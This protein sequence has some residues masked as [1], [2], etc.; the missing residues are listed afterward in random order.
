MWKKLSVMGIWEMQKNELPLIS[1][2]PIE[3]NK[4]NSYKKRSW[5]N[6][7]DEGKKK[8]CNYQMKK[9]HT[10]WKNKTSSVQALG[11]IQCFQVLKTVCC[12]SIRIQSVRAIFYVL[13]MKY[14]SLLVQNILLNVQLPKES[15]DFFGVGRVHICL[16][17]FAHLSL[18]K[19]DVKL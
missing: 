7:N 13:F 15:S 1:L 16:V 14:F 19:V 10:R 17:I 11:N 6:A 9:V 4:I 2:I 5:L 3:R 12:C 8:F 18:F